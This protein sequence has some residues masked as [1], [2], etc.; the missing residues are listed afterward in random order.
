MGF[1]R[2][3]YIVL[4][5][6]RSASA[7]STSL[8]LSMHSAL[9]PPNTSCR[10]TVNRTLLMTS[11][12]SD[13]QCNASHLNASHFSISHC[14]ALTR[15]YLLTLKSPT[16]ASIHRV[17]FMHTTT[18]ASVCI[19][20]CNRYCPPNI[21]AQPYCASK[22]NSISTSIA[23]LLIMR[24]RRRC[25]HSQQ[26]LYSRNISSYQ[27]HHLIQYI[28][29]RAIASLLLLMRTLA[30]A[31]LP[32]NWGRLAGAR[33][34]SPPPCLYRFCTSDRSIQGLAWMGGSRTHRDQSK[35]LPD[36]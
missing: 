26:L 12:P 3:N 1:I 4:V 21:H 18:A 33:S 27:H 22:Y 25:K 14:F 17:E 5:H 8:C 34:T 10:V 32:S 11:Q 23:W 29:Y 7:I 13:S 6:Y 35:L 16:L 36:S 9:N 28:I 2:G 15:Y 19:N 30:P 20:A 31:M 24:T